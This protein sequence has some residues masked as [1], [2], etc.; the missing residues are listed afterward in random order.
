MANPDRLMDK[1]HLSIDQALHRG[2]IHRD[3]IAH[4]HRWGHVV[5]HLMQRHNYK[6]MHLIDVGCGKDQ[7]LPRMLYSSKMTGFDYSG[8]DINKL[9]IDES[10]YKAHVNGKLRAAIYEE[11]DASVL[12]PKQLKWGL[13][14]FLVCFEV[15]EHMQPFI[16][17]RML[18][19]WK[20]LLKPGGIAF[21]STPVHNGSAAGN[22]INEM[23]RKTLGSAFE[24]AG[25]TIVEN[26]GTFAS[27]S[28][29]YPLLN[30][31][32]RLLHE[33]L[34]AYYDSN[35]LSTIFAPL[36]PEG[37][38]NNLWVLKNEVD[39]KPKFVGTEH[40]ELNQNPDIGELFT[41]R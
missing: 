5:K 18:N 2:F 37:S 11:T 34:K 21:V 40:G 39:M 23:G 16:A 29:I 13:G 6:G 10:L 19:N 27:Q 41:G 28:E 12:D 33:K 38:R 8:I 20:R 36:H 1:S 7:P 30:A 25:F 22:H 3:Y 17:H 24:M 4:C 32:E 14:D 9:E 35:V 15:L 26:Y 31:E